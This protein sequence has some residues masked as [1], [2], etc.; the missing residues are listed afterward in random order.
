M[1]LATATAAVVGGCGGGDKSSGSEDAGKHSDRDVADLFQQAG[2]LFDPR[3]R[4]G[5]HMH[6]D[7]AGINRREEIFA[8]ERH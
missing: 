2:G 8:Q 5:A 7:L 3:A 1:L 6:Q 4:L